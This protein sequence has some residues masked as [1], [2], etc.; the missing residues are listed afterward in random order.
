MRTRE[1]E[2]EERGEE[3]LLGVLPAIGE[4]DV[5][6]TWYSLEPISYGSRC[7]CTRRPTTNTTTHTTKGPRDRGSGHVSQDSRPR[8]VCPTASKDLDTIRKG[9]QRSKAEQRQEDRP[10]GHDRPAT[11]TQANPMHQTT[12]SVVHGR[13]TDLLAQARPSTSPSMAG[14]HQ[15]CSNGFRGPLRRTRGESG[16]FL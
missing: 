14:Q 7:Q 5:T 16:V 2:K 11:R 13:H 4:Q 6:Y 12:Q 8:A 15:L 3:S 1:G 10:Q 9:G